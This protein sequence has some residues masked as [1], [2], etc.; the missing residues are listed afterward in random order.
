MPLLVS[1]N[2]NEESTNYPPVPSTR[3]SWNRSSSA[4]LPK[5]VSHWSNLPVRKMG[6][7]AKAEWCHVFT[8]RNG[9]V[10]QFR[11]FTDTASFAD[12]YRA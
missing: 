8:F 4:R 6:K 7:A 12:A 10:S 2:T 9:K 1:T 5:F 11:E 3:V